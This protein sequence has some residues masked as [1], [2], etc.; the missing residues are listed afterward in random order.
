[1]K[2]L[3]YSINAGVSK[4]L[5]ENSKTIDDFYS[6]INI[7]P[8]NL[9]YMGKGDFGE[10]YSIGDGRILKITSSKSEFELAQ[11]MEGQD[12]PALDSFA[13]IYK[14]DVV[15]GK[16]LIVLE[17]L[18]QDSNIEGLF[19]ELLDILDEHYL[20]IQYLGHLD[21]DNVEISD[22]LKS[23]MDDIEGILYGYR[24]LGIE[25]AD[26]RPENMGYSKDGKIKAFDIDDKGANKWR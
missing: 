8:D 1:M 7:D 4:F 3:K 24:Y 15:D 17:E 12:I 19:Y 16:M 14:T 2:D 21:T 22:E 6:E 23:F 20:P 25:V 18:I 9:S 10:A 13:K 26:I 11:Q 5:N